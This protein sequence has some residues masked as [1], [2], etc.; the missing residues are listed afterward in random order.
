MK[1]VEKSIAVIN[2]LKYLVQGASQFH[3]G[4]W[5]VTIRNP[6]AWRSF[7]YEGATL[8]EACDKAATA[9]AKLGEA[10][11]YTQRENTRRRPRQRVKLASKRVRL[12]RKRVCL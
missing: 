11:P 3:Y 4:G 1:T 8:A 9:C 2:G 7:N 10:K 12:R 5:L 6:F